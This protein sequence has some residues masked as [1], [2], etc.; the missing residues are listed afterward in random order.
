MSGTRLLVSQSSS[1]VR[2]QHGTFLAF[3]LWSTSLFAAEL[4]NE[5]YLADLVQRANQ[6]GLSRQR[7][8]QVLLHYRK[9]LAGDGMTSEVDDPGFF[10]SP[11]G[12]TDPRAELEATLA[13][14]FSNELVGRSQQL[15]QCAF[16]ARYQWLK[17]KLRID[18]QQLPPQPCE[19]FRRWFSEMNPQS[20]TI[21]FASAFMNNPS[22]MFGHTF[23]R[24]DQKG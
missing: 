1:L 20:V 12:K 8:W 11:H 7:D 6:V 4:N 24:I 5:A 21:V 16:I 17:A 15:T 14:L 13:K 23:L 18:D 22:S 9:D 10:L 2:I 3:L 19:R